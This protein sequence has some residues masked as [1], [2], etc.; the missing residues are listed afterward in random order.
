MINSTG[1]VAVRKIEG[2]ASILGMQGIV[3][4]VPAGFEEQ[5]DGHWDGQRFVP[6]ET[7]FRCDELPSGKGQ[8]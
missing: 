5:A 7:A 3:D 8:A 2:I 6:S 4:V 1:R